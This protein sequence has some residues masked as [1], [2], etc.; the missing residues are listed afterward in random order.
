MPISTKKYDV[1]PSQNDEL[2]LPEAPLEL[3]RGDDFVAITHRRPPE[4]FFEL[5]ASYLPR[6][7]QRADYRQGRLERCCEAEFDLHHPERVVPTYPADL[8][9]ELLKGV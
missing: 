4:G 2:V 8:L 9:E 3:P 5:C 7:R 1:S 6:L